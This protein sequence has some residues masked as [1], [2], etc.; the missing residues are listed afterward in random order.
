MAI[1]FFSNGAI[2]HI[3][4]QIANKKNAIG[5]RLSVKETGCTGLMYVPVI[6]TETSESDI[7]DDNPAPFT[8]L[9][10][11]ASKEALNDTYIDYV[12]H[13]LGQ[14]Q[15]IYDNPNADSLCGCGES[16]NLKRSGDN[17]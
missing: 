9:V 7:V 6:A 1:L 5:F 15:L 3:K 17:A 16:F 2:A 8:V 11:K 13:Q 14:R 4:E 10:D 12:E